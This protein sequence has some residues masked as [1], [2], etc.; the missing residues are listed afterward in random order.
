MKKYSMQRSLIY[1]TV[2]S[3]CV[4]PTAEWVYNKLKPDYPQLS[5]GT[6]YR[7]LNQLADN[8][9]ILRISIPGLPDMFD[10]TIAPHYHLVCESCNSVQDIHLPELSKEVQN[11]QHHIEKDMGASVTKH[12]I[13]FWTVCQNCKGKIS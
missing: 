7:N 4:H 13:I 10:S 6:V 11:M 3:N 1:D 5:L 2:K 12:E 8:G 9:D